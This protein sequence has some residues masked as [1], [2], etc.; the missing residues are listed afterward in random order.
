MTFRQVLKEAIIEGEDFNRRQL[1]QMNRDL[2][3]MERRE[4]QIEARYEPIDALVTDVLE[5]VGRETWGEGNYSIDRIPHSIV[6]RHGRSEGEKFAYAWFLC[7][8]REPRG[9]YRLYLVEGFFGSS[10]EICY[11]GGITRSNVSRSSLQNVFLTAVRRGPEKPLRIGGYWKG[12]SAD[13]AS[14]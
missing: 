3:K 10:I 11:E 5:D 7:G 14:R 2:E 1:T 6:D 4:R 9:N 12:E 13:S 8:Y